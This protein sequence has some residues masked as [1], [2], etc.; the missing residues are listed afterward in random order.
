MSSEVLFATKT[1]PRSAIQINP[2]WSDLSVRLNN[3]KSKRC[4]S[5]ETTCSSVSNV[6]LAS[7][8][9]SRESP[10]RAYLRRRSSFAGLS[11]VTFD[12]TDDFSRILHKNNS[13]STSQLCSSNL[14]HDKVVLNV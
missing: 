5:P 11:N 13:M 3:S 7:S 12:Q 9:P 14:V 2:D 6:S 4:D 8:T 1:I 10:R